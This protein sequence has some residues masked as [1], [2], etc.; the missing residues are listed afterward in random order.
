M[1]DTNVLVSA[2]GWGGPPREVLFLALA[3][4]FALITSKPQLLELE[5]VLNYPRFSFSHE[6][7]RLFTSKLL[8]VA[9]IV[10]VSGSLKVIEKDPDDDVILE[11]ALEGNADFLISGDRHLLELREYRGVKILPP[12]DFLA[13]IS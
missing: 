10:G 2:L 4:E 11:T 7:K 13:S 1:L 9:I 6:E 5:K 12:A 3:G 8:E